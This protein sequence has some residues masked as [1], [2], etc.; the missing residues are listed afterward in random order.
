MSVCM[1]V[2]MYV[3]VCMCVCMYVCMYVCMHVC[4]YACMYACPVTSVSVMRSC[5]PSPPQ[6]SS[7]PSSSSPAAILRLARKWCQHKCDGWYVESGSARL[8]T[9]Q[10]RRADPGRCKSPGL[11][12]PPHY[13]TTCSTSNKVQLTPI[14]LNTGRD[15]WE[16]SL[17]PASLP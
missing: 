1:C 3:C 14:P 4:M 13:S 8:R 17:V 5:G 9:D 11:L 6:G 2:C 15:F 12:R 16:V 10:G 7:K